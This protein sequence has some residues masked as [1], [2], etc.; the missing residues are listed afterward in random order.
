MD[1]CEQVNIATLA[2]AAPAVT[3]E[4][5]TAAN[6]AVAGEAPTAANGPPAVA[7]SAAIPSMRAPQLGRDRACIVACLVNKMVDIVGTFTNNRGRNCPHHA[8]CGMQLQVGSM[9]CFRRERS[10][11]REGREEDVLRVYVMGDRAMMC[12][13]EFLPPH[14]AVRADAYNGLYARSEGLLHC[15]SVR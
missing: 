12:K 1:C 8:C 6:G 4:M 11:F 9:V 15:L 5:P 10:I 13:V 3:G 2:T 14:L 7:E